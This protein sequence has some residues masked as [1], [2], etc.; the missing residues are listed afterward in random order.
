MNIEVSFSGGKKVNA[1]FKNFTIKT[2]QPICDGGEGA[3]PEPFSLFIASIGTC[4]GFY[5]L[6]F[7][8]KRNIPTEGIKLFLKTVKYKE[9]HL[10]SKIEI[11]IKLPKGF[12][13][14]YKKAVIRAAEQ[15]TVKKHLDNPP[16][17]EIFTT[18][19]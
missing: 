6:S 16:K 13:D 9:I 12:P 3:A 8:Q 17:I 1:K 7:C 18:K 11:E 4:I 19:N 5:V 14:Q 2:D 15:C 10:I